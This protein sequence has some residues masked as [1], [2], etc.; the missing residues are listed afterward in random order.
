MDN[1]APAMLNQARNDEKRD[2]D[3]ELAQNIYR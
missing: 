2:E 1:V 3:M